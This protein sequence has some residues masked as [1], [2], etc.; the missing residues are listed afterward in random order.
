MTAEERRRA[1]LA[2]LDAE[3]WRFADDVRRHAGWPCEKGAS[4]RAGAVLRQ[5]WLAGLADRREAVYGPMYRL[6]ESGWREWER[7]KGVGA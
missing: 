2:A 3:K 1:V 7:L 6:N 4:I 5:L